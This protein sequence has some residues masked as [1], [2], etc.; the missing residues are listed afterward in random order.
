[1]N[2]NST[3]QTIKKQAHKYTVFVVNIVR[4]T[5]KNKEVLEYRVK[6]GMFKEETFEQRPE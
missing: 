6:Q 2:K 3:Y 1:M 4:E 5:K